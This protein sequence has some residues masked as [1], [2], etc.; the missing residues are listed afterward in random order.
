MMTGPAL[1]AFLHTP[2]D[3]GDSEPHKSQHKHDD[4]IGMRVPANNQ[5]GHQGRVGESERQKYL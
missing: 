5:L 1:D 4:R 3:Y 2:R